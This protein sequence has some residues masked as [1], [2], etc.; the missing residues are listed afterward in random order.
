MSGAVLVA[1]SLVVGASPLDSAPVTVNDDGVR[2]WVD[3]VEGR[4]A[5]EPLTA[6]SDGVSSC[7]AVVDGRPETEPLT[8]KAD[9]V[10][11]CS[12]VVDG[13]PETE[14]LT[15]KADG[16]GVLLVLSILAITMLVPG[17][18]RLRDEESSGA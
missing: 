16:V 4:P 17:H 13:R 3:V 2:V 10:S 1:T 14:L 5:S 15:V 6:K 18:R 7:S 8:V 11:V 12:A 9:G